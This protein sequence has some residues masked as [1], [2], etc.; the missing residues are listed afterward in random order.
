MQKDIHDIIKEVQIT[1]KGT[2]LIETERK[3]FFKV[4]TW[5][6]KVDV[7]RAVEQLFNVRV[8]AVNMMNYEGKKKRERTPNFGK[9]AD[10]KRAIV[11]LAEGERID[12]T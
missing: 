1:E 5:A 9:R 3:Y 7:K 8:D 6:N 12:M 4:A 2:V 11:T 10:W